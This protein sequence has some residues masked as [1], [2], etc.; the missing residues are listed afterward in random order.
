LL[1]GRSFLLGDA[2]T[3]AD[4]TAGTSLYRYFELEIER[5]QLRQVERWYHALAQ[6]PAY[7]EHV[8]IPFGEL[9]GR[10]DY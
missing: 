7:R 2:L 6:R 5:P 8:M 9:R 1:E 3:L 4:I 10:L